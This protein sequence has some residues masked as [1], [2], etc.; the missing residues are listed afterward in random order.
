MA[1]KAELREAE[2]LNLQSSIAADAMRRW[3][4]HPKPLANLSRRH[5]DA[6]CSVREH[7]RR[8]AART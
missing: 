4:R 3:K 5:P 6:Y 1:R 7:Q 2:Y 8:K